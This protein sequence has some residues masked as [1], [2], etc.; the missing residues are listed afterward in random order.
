MLLLLGVGGLF[1]LEAPN[2][3]TWLQGEDFVPDIG[4][5]KQQLEAGLQAASLY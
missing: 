2:G 5:I 4:S 1:I 3:E